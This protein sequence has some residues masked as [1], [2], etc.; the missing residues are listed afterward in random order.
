MKKAFLNFLIILFAG[1][2]SSCSII[3][4]VTVTGISD[5]HTMNRG[6][7]PEIWFNLQLNNPNNFAVT[8]KKVDIGISM[9]EHTLVRSSI[10]EETEITR[11]EKSMVTVALK[12]SAEKMAEIFKA[13]VN[14]ILSGKKDQFQITGEIQVKKFIFTRKYQVKEMIN[15]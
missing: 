7:E 11:K 13:G 12:P 8:I 2:V 14:G 15:L 10:L 5:F 6:E 1:L 4:P 9:G 3:K